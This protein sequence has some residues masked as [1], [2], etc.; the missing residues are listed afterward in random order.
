MPWR[1]ILDAPRFQIAFDSIGPSMRILLAEDHPQLA[2]SLSQ[3]LAQSGFAVDSVHDGVTADQLLQSEPFALVVL[4]IAMPRMD[5]WEVLRRLRARGARVPV[6]VLTAHGSTQDRVRGL[7][8]G[9]DDYLAKPFELAELEARVRALLRR[10][11]GHE[12][13]RI[14]FGSLSLDTLTRGFEAA[15]QPLSLTPRERAVLEV[16]MLRAGKAIGKEALSAQVYSLDDN[17]S[18]DAIEVYVHRL[19]KKLAGSGVTVATLRGLGYLLEQQ[20]AGSSDA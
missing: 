4:D 9:A 3:A 14:E 7:D 16:L 13:T 2:H 10:S 17:A 11:Q 20:A 1:G 5:G 15:G 8:L 19:R 18:P 12:G 6:L